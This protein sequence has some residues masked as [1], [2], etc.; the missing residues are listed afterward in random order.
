MARNNPLDGKLVVLFGGGG[1]V[2][3]HV[4]QA[5]LARGARLRIAGRSAGDAWSLKPLANLGQMQ[6]AP[7]DV[8]HRG[9][10]A[11]A[12]AGADA[13]VNLVGSFHGDLMA[14]MGA[15]AGNI[16][17]AAAAA[18]VES[19][20]QVSAIGADAGSPSRYAQAKAAGEAAVQSAFPSATIIRPSV[21]FGQQAGLIPLIAGMVR[22]WPIVPVFAPHA[23]LRA[24]FVGDAAGAIVHA[25]ADPL[26]HGGKIYEIAGPEDLTMLGLHDE[27]ARLQ[28]RKRLFPQVPDALSA[29]MTK[30]PLVPLSSDQWEM[31]KAGNVPSGQYPGIEALG[32]EPKPIGLFLDRWMTRYRRHGRF[33]DHLRTA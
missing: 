31:L 30:L 33:S 6:F 9:S 20:V 18:G 23:P 8:R 26:A 22:T 12:L 24:L 7:C 17:E 5:L 19:L 3:T 2:G 1:F 28:G 15:G 14:L 13:A 21:L 10:V 25:L 27:V 11:A 16:A 32:V 29:L 4:A